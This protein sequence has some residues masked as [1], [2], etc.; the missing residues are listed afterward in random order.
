MSGTIKEFLVEEDA[1]VSVGQDL[2]VM[3]PGE[4]G[5]TAGSPDKSGEDTSPGPEAS[6]PAGAA[7]S[8]AKNAE[9]GNKDTAAPAA[10]PEKGAPKDTHKKQEEI[11]PGMDAPEKKAAEQ[12]SKSAPAPPPKKEEKKS[13]DSAPAP[14]KSVGSRNE[15]RVSG[16]NHLTLL[17]NTTTSK[18]NSQ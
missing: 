10:K 9:D 5:E 2:L 13:A 14:V 15:T 12:E 8:E 6:K 18:A 11:A 7:K 17:H 1:T 3:E 16:P 4:G